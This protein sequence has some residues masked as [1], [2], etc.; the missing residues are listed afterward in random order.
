MKVLNFLILFS[1]MAISRA[2]AQEAVWGQS[3]DSEYGG[4]TIENVATPTGEVLLFGYYNGELAVGNQV[5]VPKYNNSGSY[6]IKLANDSS[7][8]S[9]FPVDGQSVVIENANIDS[10]G[11]IVIAGRFWESIEFDGQEYVDQSE[12]TSFKSSFIAKYSQDGTA[13]W[14]KIFPNSGYTTLTVDENDDIY[15]LSH[16]M[17]DY[18]S[19]SSH[20]R[21]FSPNGAL[22]FD[23][24][25]LLESEA[26]SYPRCIDVRNGEVLVGGTVDGNGTIFDSLTFTGGGAGFYLALFKSDGSTKWAKKIG[27]TNYNNADISDVMFDDDGS[28]YIAGGLSDNML[29]ARYDTQGSLQWSKKSLPQSFASGYVSKGIDGSIFLATNFYDKAEID[30]QVLSATPDS[31]MVL[32]APNVAL[33]KFN[34]AGNILGIQQF[35]PYIVNLVTSISVSPFDEVF[36]SGFSD[37]PAIKVGTVNITSPNDNWENAGD[38]YVIKFDGT[39]LGA[40]GFEILAD[41]DCINESIAFN[42]TFYAS[43]IKNI[44]WDFGDPVSGSQNSSIQKKTNAHGYY[45]ERTWHILA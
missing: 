27:E 37:A 42:T 14:L 5:L 16:E 32:N 13:H 25:F 3:L 43:E 2:F 39:S 12:S 19:T 10:K 40:P 7:V 36:I 35:Q 28:F 44:I 22:V 33:I 29:F 9:F 6:L 8:I 1:V 30:G 26:R 18:Y 34:E 38:G 41:E 4:V 23:N 20:L 31:H 17:M 24:K 15:V 45:F 11:D 21:K